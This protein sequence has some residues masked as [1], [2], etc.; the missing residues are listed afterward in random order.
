MSSARDNCH[1]TIRELQLEVDSMRERVDALV[2][3]NQR[4]V[5]TPVDKES[6]FLF[7]Q[8]SAIKKNK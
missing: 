6:S 5:E 7:L 8:Y 2:L 4:D 1:N 3:A